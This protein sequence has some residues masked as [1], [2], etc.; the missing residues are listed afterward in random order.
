MARTSIPLT[1]LSANGSIAA[2][3]GTA[4]DA[5]N[6]M[7]VVIPTWAIPRTANVENLVLI[8]NNTAGSAKQVTVRAGMNPPAS[9]AARGDLTVSVAAGGTRYL[10]PFESARFIQTDATLQI[11]FESGTT[12][13]VT[14]LLLPRM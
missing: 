13:T 6:G 2:P 12:G 8:L 9:Q 14:A 5:T 3:A 11:D 10:G 4:I 7:Q 1:N